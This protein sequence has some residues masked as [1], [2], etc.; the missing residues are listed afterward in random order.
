MVDNDGV[1]QAQANKATI[2]PTIAAVTPATH[3]QIETDAHD[4]QDD[5]I[6]VMDSDVTLVNEDE[7]DVARVDV[8]D[9]CVRY[10]ATRAYMK[11]VRVLVWGARGGG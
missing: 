2:I 3:A 7:E 6:R 4:D 11:A 8:D 10:P 1:P 9:V 5:E